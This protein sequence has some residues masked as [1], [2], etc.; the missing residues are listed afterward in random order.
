MTP[1]ELLQE[2][3]D[4]IKEISEAFFGWLPDFLDVFLWQVNW[5]DSNLTN[6]LFS[7]CIYAYVFGLAVNKISEMIE[8]RKNYKE[9]EVYR[10]EFDEKKAR[11]KA[12][13][14][15]DKEEGSWLAGWLNESMGL[16]IVFAFLGVV[17]AIVKIIFDAFAKLIS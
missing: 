3:R 17:V 12:D 4:T 6:I 11:L 15:R 14:D 2:I 9:D 13:E 1:R 7:L 8:H 10:R 5:L 16:L